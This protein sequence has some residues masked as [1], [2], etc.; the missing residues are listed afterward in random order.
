[1][2]EKNNEII[3]EIAQL[4]INEEKIHKIEKNMIDK[5]IF[6]QNKIEELI[7]PS[8]NIDYIKEENMRLICELNLILPKKKKFEIDSKK[9]QKHLETEK[10]IKLTQIAKKHKDEINNFLKEKN[11]VMKKIETL[12]RDSILS[13]IKNSKI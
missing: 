13:K 3:R 1:M 12:E 5:R 8:N 6:F 11:I 7:N 4:K 2:N 9:I 10:N